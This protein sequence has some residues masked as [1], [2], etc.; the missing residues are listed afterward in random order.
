MGVRTRPV[1]AAEVLAV[2]QT[3]HRFDGLDVDLALSFDTTV[4][5][6]RDVGELVAWRALGRALDADWSVGAS[7]DAWE[8]VLE[9]ARRRTLRDVC[10]LIA[11]QA[12]LPVVEPAGMLGGRC[13]A[14]GALRAMRA[15]GGRHEQGVVR[16]RPSTPLGPR[17]GDREWA[18]VGA[19]LKLAPGSIDPP[20]RDDHPALACFAGLCVL[21]VLA[22]PIG[23]L[24][25]GG[26][27]LLSH[28]AGTSVPPGD[29]WAAAEVA[30]TILLGVGLAGV[31]LT[32]RLRATRFHWGEVRTV[33]DLARRVAEGAVP[34]GG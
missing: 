2:F 19:A 26:A 25:A 27:W 9:P 4:E 31:W 22:V 23:A 34:A 21:G 12:R 30:F 10:E 33:G 11:S 24:L 15:V 17:S 20:E 5:Q 32:L 18:L 13:D 1:S 3:R 14:A 7:D 29:V 16:L 28:V 8:R 6:W